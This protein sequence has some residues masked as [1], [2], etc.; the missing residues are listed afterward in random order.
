MISSCTCVS[1]TLVVSLFLG[2][3]VSIICSGDRIGA[4]VRVGLESHVVGPSLETDGGSFALAKNMEPV[5][6]LG[7]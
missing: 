1:K 2:F 4:W 7:N 3:L 6:S 5:T